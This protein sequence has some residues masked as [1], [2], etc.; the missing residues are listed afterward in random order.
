M[1]SPGY[2]LL[3]RLSLQERSTQALAHNIANADT[4]GF[5]AMRPVFGQ[6]MVSLRG[7]GGLPGDSSMSLPQDR[8][9]W[10]DMSQ[11]SIQATGNPLDV[12]LNGEGYF[13]VETPQ[14]ER[15][16]RAGRFSIAANGR[17]VDQEGNAVLDSRNRPISFSAQDT[18]IEI[19]ANGTIQSENGEI[20][21]LQLVRFEKPQNLI[22]EGNRLFDAKNETPQPVE[23]P[24]V[25]QRV[26]EGSNVS[27]VLE[28]TRL[29]AEMREFQYAS[30]FTEREGER[31]T[32]AVER[33]LR[34]R[35]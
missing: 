21:R 3:S 12:A 20:A 28:I 6:V 23:K 19:T 13:V 27:P 2:I 33:I 18:Q 5:R 15:Y 9:T 24:N 31:I 17:L 25:V 34:R 11:G 22:A 26:L 29:T 10:R 14:G 8:A 4:P 1:D 30:M 35:S 7:A 32:N 16:T